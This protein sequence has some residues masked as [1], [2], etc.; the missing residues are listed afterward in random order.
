MIPDYQTLMLPVLKSVSEKESS[1]PEV[2]Q[3]LITKYGLTE[4]EQ[5][6]LLPSGKQTS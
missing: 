4:E 3:K 6:Q 2:I 5:Q 1:T